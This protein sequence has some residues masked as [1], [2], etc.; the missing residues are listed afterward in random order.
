MRGQSAVVWQ[1]VSA[2]ISD[3]PMSDKLS[4][5]R[6]AGLRIGPDSHGRADQRES[7]VASVHTHAASA[8]GSNGWRTRQRH[9]A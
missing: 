6:S 9:R 4:D 3:P 5:N 1:R 2:L 8:W 7:I